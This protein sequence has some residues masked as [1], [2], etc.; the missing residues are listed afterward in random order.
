[1]AMELESKIMA[2]IGLGNHYNW[3]NGSGS[4]GGIRRDAAEKLAEVIEKHHKAGDRIAPP[5]K[6]LV[7]LVKEVAG[8]GDEDESTLTKTWVVASYI[9]AEHIHQAKSTDRDRQEAYD[10]VQAYIKKNY[11]PASS[12]RGLGFMQ[13]AF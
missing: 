9:I 1:M 10:R 11:L 3:Y 12:R 4:C 8:A 13:G 5:D 7:K 2:E 6:V